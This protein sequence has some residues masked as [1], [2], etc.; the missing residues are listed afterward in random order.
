VDVQK[1]RSKT[2]TLYPEE[3]MASPVATLYDRD[4]TAVDVTLTATASA[5]STTVATYAS[6]ARQLVKVASLTGIAAG[7]RVRVT[8]A[9]FGTAVATVSAVTDVS[10]KLVRFVDPLPAIPVNGDVVVGLDVV[11][12]L[13]AFDDVYMGYVL[14]VASSGVE[15]TIREEIN[16]VRFPFRG[17]VTAQ[18]VRAVVARGWAGEFSKD[19]QKHRQIAQE[20]N[21][22]IRARL[23]GSGVYASRYWSPSA[24]APVVAPMIKLVL[25][26]Q[27]GL[28]EGGADREGYL[29]SLRFEVRDRLADVIKGAQPYDA[30]GDGA[31]SDVESLGS[32]V[33]EFQ[34]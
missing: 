23:M 25:A 16:V 12:P 17:P 21:E 30:D 14:E 20:S 34:R 22:Q 28:R 33:S 32:F 1:D 27:H 19:E 8:S 13:P 9:E 29:T 6:M 15:E 24:L 18:A 5:V 31:L 10:A 3:P 2:V 4:G 26:E 11:V 7:V